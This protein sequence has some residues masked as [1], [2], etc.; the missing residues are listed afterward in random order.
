MGMNEDVLGYVD[1]KSVAQLARDMIDIPSPVGG[2]RALAEYLAGR[3]K[4]AGLRTEMQEVEPNRFNV[5]GRLEGTGGGPT[6][7]YA[8]HL[9]SAYGGDY[10]EVEYDRPRDLYARDVVRG[11][12]VNPKYVSLDTEKV[13]GTLSLDTPAGAI[14][15]IGVGAPDLW[16]SDPAKAAKAGQAK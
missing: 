7:L 11:T 16:W 2:E 3:F 8:G 5:F 14:K 4:S 6:L 9:D 1:S 15:Y 13:E 12:K 10:L